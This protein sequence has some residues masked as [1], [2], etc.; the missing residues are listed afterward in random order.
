M[1]L[2]GA[3]PVSL[4]EQCQKA[5][6]EIDQAKDLQPRQLEEVIDHV[7]RE[8]VRLRDALIEQLRARDLAPVS[9]RRHSALEKINVALSLILTVAY[10]VTAIQRSA[11]KEAHDCLAAII[12]QNELPGPQ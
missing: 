1:A 2:S 7:Q 10:P 8:I 11:L 5:M 12:D 3:E 9:G 6:K 4:A